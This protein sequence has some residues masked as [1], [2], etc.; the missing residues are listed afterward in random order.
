MKLSKKTAYALKTVLELALNG[1]QKLMSVPQ[2][3]ARQDIPTSFLEQIL[4]ML[5]GTGFVG[6]KRGQH[7]GYYLAVAPDKITMAAVVQLT[8][9]GLQFSDNPDHTCPIQEVW[10]K[11]SLGVAEQLESTTIADLCARYQE[12]NQMNSIGYFI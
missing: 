12:R 8:E 4:L 7:G 10:N 11:I 1:E 5:K 6:S 9:G 2:I 3:S